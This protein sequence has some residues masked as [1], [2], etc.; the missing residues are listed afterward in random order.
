MGI[1]Q[2]YFAYNYILKHGCGVIVSLE[3]IHFLRLQK[4]HPDTL[5][6]FVTVGLTTQLVVWP[7]SFT[8]ESCQVEASDVIVVATKAYAYAFLFTSTP[9]NIHIDDARQIGEIYI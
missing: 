2:P 1:G 8:Y 9:S 3:I 7:L 4:S 5:I 6:G